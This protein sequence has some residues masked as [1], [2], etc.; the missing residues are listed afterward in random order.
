MLKGLLFSALWTVLVGVLNCSWQAAAHA[1]SRDPFPSERSSQETYFIAVPHSETVHDVR[2]PASC[3]RCPGM[4]HA[5]AARLERVG[6][7]RANEVLRAAKASKGT[8]LLV[9]WDD[10]PDCSPVPWR[11]ASRPYWPVGKRGF[12]VAVARSEEEWRNGRPIFDVHPAFLAPYPY[13]WFFQEGYRGT[14]VAGKSDL[15]VDEYW[16]LYEALPFSEALKAD[17]AAALQPAQAWKLRHPELTDRYPA[18]QM[19]D[20]LPWSALNTPGPLPP[21]KLRP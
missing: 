20:W 5:Q 18:P 4:L 6:G 8:V 3:E 14:K 1:C 2:Q 12:F 19:L 9:P 17:P 11:Y 10:A 7:Q 13:A 15:S 21:E 16:E